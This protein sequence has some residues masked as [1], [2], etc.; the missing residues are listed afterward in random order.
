MSDAQ[1]SPPQPRITHPVTSIA[2]R[3]RNCGPRRPAQVQKQNA[4]VHHRGSDEDEIKCSASRDLQFDGNRW[5]VV[6]CHPSC[7]ISVFLQGFVLAANIQSRLLHRC[8]HA[9]LGF[10]GGSA[11]KETARNE[12]NAAWATGLNS[13]LARSAG[14]GNG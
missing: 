9:L 11:V 3:L 10:P 6:P 1:D 4:P 5:K 8:T 12:G 14:E 13:G 7:S 2:P